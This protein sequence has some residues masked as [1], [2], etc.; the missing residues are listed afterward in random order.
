VTL[1]FFHVLLCRKSSVPIHNDSNRARYLSSLED[2]D[3]EPLVP[4][5]RHSF[6]FV[7]SA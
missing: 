3:E 1:V 7:L 6:S 4:S 5:H 2:S